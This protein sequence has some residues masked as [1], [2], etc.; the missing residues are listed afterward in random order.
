MKTLII[1]PA[2]SVT[3]LAT[4]A[5]A[6][7]KR[8]LAERQ[9]IRVK[10]NG[11]PADLTLDIAPGIG[12]EGFRI[13]EDGRGVRLEGNDERGLIY[14]VGKYLR[15]PAWRGTSV[16]DKPFRCIYFA[17]HFHNVYHDG[18]VEFIQQYVEE[19]A[20]WGC[21][22]LAVWFDMHHYTGMDDPAAQAMVARLRAILKAAQ[23]VGMTLDL[24]CLANEGFASSPLE[25]RAD[26]RFGD[27]GYRHSIGSYGVEVCPSKPEGQA[28]L[29]ESR[30]QMLNAFR[31]LDIGMLT[32]WPYDQ[33]GCT[34]EDC[35]PW[36]ANGY[37]KA[38]EAVAG[39]ART[40][41]PDVKITLSTWY[42]D[43]HTDGEWEGL[44]RAFAKR[45]D[46]VDY[47]MVDNAGKFPEYPLKHGIPGGLPAVSFPEISMQDMWPWGGFGANPRPQHWQQYW[48]RLRPVLAGGMAYSE[49]I[50][51]DINKVLHLQHCWG[52]DRSSREITRDYASYEFGPANADD[53]VRL[54][55]DL[56]VAMTE[57]GAMIEAAGNVLANGGWDR[58]REALPRV[59]RVKPDIPAGQNLARAD[60]MAERMP[61]ARRE[62]WRWRVLWLRVALDAELTRS[63][64]RP[65][66]QSEAYFDELTRLF[67]AGH[68]EW[69]VT[70]PSIKGMTR[71]LDAGQYVTCLP[72]A[73][74]GPQFGPLLTEWMYSSLL[75]RPV[76][77]VPPVRLADPLNWQL[78]KA[79]PRSNGL[80]Y[81][82]SMFWNDDG[83]VYLAMRVRVASEGQWIL[84]I[85]HDGG[86]R[87]FVD[88]RAV[89]TEPELQRPVKLF[90]SKARLT[91]GRGLHEI[92]VAFDTH[93]G[94]A[95]GFGCFFESTRKTGRHVF[96]RA[97][98]WPR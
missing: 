87:V 89:I 54:L 22:V 50:Y 69:F 73:P 15:D 12:E 83:L 93:A 30:R 71:L 38:S 5:L 59:Y 11:G 27:N 26:C 6:I 78:L 64:C 75:P 47:L 72:D 85:G 20:L 7:L 34:C 62:A 56:E 8:E 28:Q 98:A 88:G 23:D 74:Q 45:P 10:R 79:L 39:L 29:L 3:P 13:S 65:T 84:H 76:G 36:G 90:R 55:E 9:G 61:A 41:F 33:G 49:G 46:W 4:K 94:L 44:D 66:A 48:D 70:P 92:V 19:L 80:M 57:H 17:S 77:E 2:F 63:Q 67:S 68:A 1:D 53:G 81:V 40:V 35:F 60:R 24:T 14:A 82:H 32:L 95:N 25:S 96:P 51:E 52:D 91:L 42:F 37:L 31:D 43:K 18:P 58:C 86:V 21:N 16:P 97:V